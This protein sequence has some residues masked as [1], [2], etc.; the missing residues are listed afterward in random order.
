MSDISR[1]PGWWQASD[2]KWYPPESHPNA[3]AAVSSPVRQAAATTGVVTS[4]TLLAPDSVPG[5]TRGLRRWLPLAAV[6]LVV[7][8]GLVVLLSSVFGSVSAAGAD[9]PDAAFDGMMAALDTEDGLVSLVDLDDF[10]LAADTLDGGRGQGTLSE[11]FPGG[12]D[13]SLTELDGA[14]V[15]ATYRV[16]GDAEAGLMVAELDGVEITLARTGEDAAAIL[17]FDAAMLQVF[18]TGEID[19]GSELVIEMRPRGGGF[20]VSAS[21][22]F[23]GERLPT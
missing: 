2:G 9:S 19:A 3:R 23:N 17:L 16:L 11:G 15:T 4:E 10:G 6:V 5:K 13:F 14:P 7:G 20:D 22:S 12:I 8:V 1:G 21:G 18:S